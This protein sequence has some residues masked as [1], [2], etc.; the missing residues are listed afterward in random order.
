MKIGHGRDYD[1]VQPLRGLY[2]G[3]FQHELEVSVRMTRLATGEAWEVQA[4]AQGLGQ[5]QRQF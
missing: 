2:H 1:D 3:P 4:Q 5:T